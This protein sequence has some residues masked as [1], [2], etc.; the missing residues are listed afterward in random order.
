MTTDPGAAIVRQWTTDREYF[1]RTLAQLDAASA[2]RMAEAAV[3]FHR[4]HGSDL[5]VERQLAAWG[6]A[7]QCAIEN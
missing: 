6:A 5:T 7:Q 3:A 1:L 2:V 4:K